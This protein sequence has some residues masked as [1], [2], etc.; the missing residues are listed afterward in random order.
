MLFIS[1][2]SYQAIVRAYSKVSSI[3]Y[4]FAISIIFLLVFT[5]CSLFGNNIVNHQH[6]LGYFSLFSGIS[7]IRLCSSIWTTKPDKV[8]DSS[9]LKLSVKS[10]TNQSGILSAI[11]D[12]LIC[13]KS[14]TV[15]L[16]Y[17]KLF[18]YRK[19]LIDC[20]SFNTLSSGKTTIV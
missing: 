3:Q 20:N 17:L 18:L 19:S 8:K 10:D 11:T 13:A 9:H 16:E 7:K 2:F 4:L 6:Q 12:R 14:D 1:F 15:L 5:R